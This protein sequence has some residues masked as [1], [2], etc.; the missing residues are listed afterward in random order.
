[1]RRGRD[2][3]A[4]VGVCGWLLRNDDRHA[5]TLFLVAWG[6]VLLLLPTILGIGLADLRL[7]R[8][9]RRERAKELSRVR[10]LNRS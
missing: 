10:E 1:M 4:R 6:A 3:S 2:D 7:T 8:R 5:T 9:L